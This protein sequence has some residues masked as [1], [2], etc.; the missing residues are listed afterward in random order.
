VNL[1]PFIEGLL[2]LNQNR[3]KKEAMKLPGH[4]NGLDDEWLLRSAEQKFQ[5]MS[6]FRYFILIIVIGAI[7][8]FFL[9]Y[10]AL[11]FFF[12]FFFLGFWVFAFH[13]LIIS[14][15]RCD[16]TSA[17]GIPRSVFPLSGA[18]SNQQLEKDAVGPVFVSFECYLEAIENLAQN[19]CQQRQEY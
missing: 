2:L 7:C 18:I 5:S 10:F 4:E 11:F 15:C 9:L 13:I 16:S 3:Q 12:F 1:I 6:L 17:R 19:L 8:D 14:Q